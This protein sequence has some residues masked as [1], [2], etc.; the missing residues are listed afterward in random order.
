MKL[1]D[2][3]IVITGGASGIGR[4][5][6]RRALEM[7]AKA[8]AVWDINADNLATVVEEHSKIG[9]AKGYRVDVSDYDAVQKAYSETVADLGP[10]DVLINNAGIVT[11]N[12]TFDLNTKQDIDRTITI[13]TVAPMYVALAMLPD[14][15]KRDRG[16]ICNITS[17]AGL[18]SMPRMSVYSASKWAAMG[19]SDSIRIELKEKKSHVNVTTIAPYFINTGMFDGVKSWFFPILDP[20]N[21]AKRI[22]RA[23][24]KNKRFK[25]MPF[26]FRFTRLMQGILP[27]C[28]ADWIF[29][30]LFGIYH[31]MDHFTGRKK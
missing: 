20:E 12:K 18:L 25:G 14:M 27:M 21:T 15:I 1:K 11:T 13:N 3:V 30:E 24:E 22:L 2:T 7:G 16:H 19:W 8:I 5:M 9:L 26:A 17:A 31:T 29:G 6:G 10:V 4:I 28:G 23:I